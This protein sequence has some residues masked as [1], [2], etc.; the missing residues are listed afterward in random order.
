VFL[1]TDEKRLGIHD[2]SMYIERVITIKSPLRVIARRTVIAVLAASAL[3]PLA[4]AGTYS[5]I[6]V[7][8]YPSNTPGFG[9]VVG[10]GSWYINFSG[11]D[12]KYGLTAGASAPWFT[13]GGMGPPVG[14]PNA[15]SVVTVQ[16]IW[17]WVVQWVGAPGEAA[18]QHITG[19]A[20]Y[21][22]TSSCAAW[23]M[24]FGG[25]G[26]CLGQLNDLFYSVSNGAASSTPG[27]QDAPPTKYSSANNIIQNLTV[28]ADFT[29]V[30]GTTNTY[31]GYFSD[32]V[33]DIASETANGTISQYGPSPTG[34]GIGSL[35][36]D[37]TTRLCFVAGQR[38]QPD[39]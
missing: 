17:Q 28:G 31:I 30:A 34:E 33:N 23:A 1:E 3:V 20:E 24:S 6:G 7:Q 13:S 35:A 11:L 21:L 39:L 36:M 32:D 29:Y 38:V 19:I 9:S 10:N 22:G 12:L 4:Q 27:Q 26:S 18:P 14:H 5:V 25:S 15:A 37:V 8:W 2:G 16:G